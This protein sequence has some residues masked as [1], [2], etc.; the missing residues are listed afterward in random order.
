LNRRI[1]DEE[2]TLDFS[3]RFGYLPAVLKELDILVSSQLLRSYSFGLDGPSISPQ[4]P[5]ALYFNDDVVVRWFPTSDHL[6]IAAQDS[7]KGTLF[8]TLAYRV[9]PLRFE[10]RNVC[11]SCH[12]QDG[13]LQSG[14]SAPGHIVRSSLNTIE[15]TRFPH[16]NQMTHTLPIEYRWTERYVTGTSSTLIH[17]GNRIWMKDNP[18]PRNVINIKDEF[19][20][21]RYLTDTSDAVA[22]LVF[23]H[24]MFGLNLLSRI[25]Y[26]HQLNVRSKVE[27]IA[28]RY[29]LLVDEAPLDHPTTGKSDYADWYQSR[30]PKD[31]E[32]RSLFDLDLGSKLFRYRISPLIQSPMV[33]N[34]PAELKLSL[35]R[36]LNDV[37]TGKEQLKGF[38]IPEADKQSTLSVVRATVPDW[39]IE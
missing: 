14:I 16:G 1:R 22:H 7:Q 36:R 39:P 27:M 4:R 20:V 32:G 34:L 37:L 15:I 12:N 38:S 2:L 28:V 3:D 23:D 17:R 19:D 33:R 21:N 25:S 8:Y 5:L 10:Q 9:A 18:T 6:E 31:A 11:M 29:L 35:F 26:E 30:G 24:Q 13:W